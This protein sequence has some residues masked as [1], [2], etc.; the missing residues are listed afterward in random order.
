M[1]WNL[2]GFKIVIEEEGEEKFGFI[3]K[4][5]LPWPIGLFR[6]KHYYEES[7]ISWMQYRLKTQ[8]QVEQKYQEL[9]DMCPA[10]QRDDF[11]KNKLAIM[12]VIKSIGDIYVDRK[13]AGKIIKGDKLAR[14]ILFHEIGHF[15]NFG[16]QYPESY[17][18]RPKAI[19]E[20][21]VSQQETDA[22]NFAFEVC[23]DDFYDAMK[24][25]LENATAAYSKCQSDDLMF[26]IVELKLRITNL[27]KIIKMKREL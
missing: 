20:G 26:L 22:D 6:E 12:I 24:Q 9:L 11:S 8:E 15:E 4:E 21:R 13:T 14:A 19:S 2:K 5:Q 27:V 18:D 1:D 3:T 16:R 23:G 10:V 25:D 7:N 17:E